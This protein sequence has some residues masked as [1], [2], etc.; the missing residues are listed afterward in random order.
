MTVEANIYAVLQPICPRVFADF[1][2]VA[3]L[4]PYVTYQQTGGQVLN[5]IG[6]DVP[7][8]QNGEFQINVW[9]DTRAVSAAL[10]LQIEAAMRQATAFNARPLSSPASDFDADIPVY[11]SRQDF[12]VWSDR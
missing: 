10:M 4:R 12:S 8:K 6:N 9:S 7:N 5:P 2:P 11:G 3:T 1:A